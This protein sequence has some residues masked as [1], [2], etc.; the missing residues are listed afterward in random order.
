MYF[1]ADKERF[2]KDQDWSFPQLDFFERN[3]DINF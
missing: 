1:K 2:M 3:L